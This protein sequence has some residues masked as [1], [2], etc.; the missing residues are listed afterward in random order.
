M[1]ASLQN[2]FL[3]KK[4]FVI[5]NK[6]KN[7]FIPL[8]SLYTSSLLSKIFSF[9]LTKQKSSSFSELSSLK[10]QMP[11]SGFLFRRF[12]GAEKF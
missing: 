10:L 3:I 11:S 12:F 7:G 5:F 8:L 2:T 6:R 4:L 1:G 9:L